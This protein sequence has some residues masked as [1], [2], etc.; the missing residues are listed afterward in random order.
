[1]IY[2]KTEYRE[3]RNHFAYFTSSAPMKAYDTNRENFLGVFN[4]WESPQ[5][6]VNG[7]CTNSRGAWMGTGRVLFREIINLAPGEEREVI[8]LLGYTENPQEEKFEI[9]GKQVIN[10]SRA[11]PVIE[12]FNQSD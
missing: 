2:H 1:M 10:K 5:A 4:G 11:L 12:R 9:P 8:F 7:N 6:V 3:R